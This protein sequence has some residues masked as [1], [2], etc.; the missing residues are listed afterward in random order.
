MVY[1]KRKPCDEKDYSGVKL[2]YV[3]KKKSFTDN[4]AKDLLIW[5]GRGGGGKRRIQKKH[6]MSLSEN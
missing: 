3:K 2:N 6:Q 1:P 5:R 4:E